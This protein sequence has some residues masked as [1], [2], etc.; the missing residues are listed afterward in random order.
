MRVTRVTGETEATMNDL[1]K[2]EFPLFSFAADI[3]HDNLV[4]V[5]VDGAFAGYA[6]RSASGRLFLYNQ[7][8]LPISND[9]D[10]MMNFQLAVLAIVRN[11]R[12]HD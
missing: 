7:N 9:K 6:V 2:L 5:T 11:Y 1:G 8:S 4:N 3:R 12:N 10:G